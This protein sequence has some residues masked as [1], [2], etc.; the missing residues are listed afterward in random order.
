MK[1]ECRKIRSTTAKM[2]DLAAQVEHISIDGSTLLD[3]GPIAWGS[4]PLPC[5]WDQSPIAF[6]PGTCILVVQCSIQEFERF[7]GVALVFVA[8]FRGRIGGGSGKILAQQIFIALTSTAFFYSN[9][10]KSTES[11]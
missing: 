7:I 6:V 9:A 11:T 5:L 3:L 8:A 10:K 4:N 2:G 1:K